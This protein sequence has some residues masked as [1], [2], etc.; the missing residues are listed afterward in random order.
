MTFSTICFASIILY[1]YVAS[2]IAAA[3]TSDT[4]PREAVGR[5]ETARA[6]SIATVTCCGARLR[7]DVQRQICHLLGKIEEGELR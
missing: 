1:L 6:L 2:W 5:E 4:G 3:N 7:F